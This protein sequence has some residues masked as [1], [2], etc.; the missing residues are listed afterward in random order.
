MSGDRWQHVNELFHAALE[1]EGAAREAFLRDACRGDEELY[2]DV[3][4]LIAADAETP[5]IA[6]E[7]LG[8]RVAEDWV[9]G[10]ERR[11]SSGGRSI[12]IRSSRT[13]GRAGWAMSTARP[14]PCSVATSR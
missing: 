8:E 1:R 11:R 12:A 6:L 3:T 4:S 2:A 10:T 14:T 7:Q 13:S 9:A 5:A